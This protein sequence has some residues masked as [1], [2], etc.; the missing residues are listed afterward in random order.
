MP[1]RE[2]VT[3]TLEKAAGGLPII[4]DGDCKVAAFGARPRIRSLHPRAPW[5][6]PPPPL[7]SC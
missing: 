1:T 2:Q 7:A 5:L 4:L 3:I 6:A